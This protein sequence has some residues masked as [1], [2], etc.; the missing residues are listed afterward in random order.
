MT[1]TILVTGASRGI[2]R[3]TAL[4]A[5]SLGWNVAVNYVSDAAAAEEVV[6][7][8]SAFG[9]RT[10]AVRGDVASETD[11]DRMFEEAT[12]H[13][14][15]LTGVVA[16]AGIVAPAS[17]LADMTSERLRR[18]VDVNIM[19]TL[20]TARAAAR[21]LTESGKPGSL[22]IVSSAASRLGSAGEY[23]D[24]AACKGAADTLTIG[25][26]RELGPRGIRVNA[27]RPAFIETEIHASGGR[28]DRAAMLGAATPMGR[29]GQPE[30]VAEAVT[31]LISDAASYVTGTFIDLSGGR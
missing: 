25:L 28:P 7:S 12:E 30:E 8:I 9:A 20:L 10:V 23:V 17:T 19:G 2:G 18:M 11:V 4:K 22:V 6:A 21:A 3:A 13:L 5:G 24:Y 29:A 16:N 1:K 14:G 31:W 27:V 26:S 15:P